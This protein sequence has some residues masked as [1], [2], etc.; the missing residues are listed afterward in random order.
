[1]KKIEDLVPPLELCQQIPEGD[2]KFTESMEVEAVGNLKPGDIGW[3]TC[4]GCEKNIHKF[5]GVLL[6]GVTQDAAK[7]LYEKVEVV[8][9]G[10]KAKMSELEASNNELLEALEF[11]C[12]RTTP[13]ADCYCQHGQGLVK[14]GHCSEESYCHVWQTIQKERGEK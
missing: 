6:Q 7:L 12:Y 3:G 10:T 1:M 14:L 13:G 5:P 9:E 4:D 2:N 11:C 8:A